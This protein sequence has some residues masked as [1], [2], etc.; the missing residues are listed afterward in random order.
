MATVDGSSGSRATV[1]QVHLE[2]ERVR[3]SRMERLQE[4]T[5]RLAAALTVQEVSDAVLAVTTD[6]LAS[7]SGVVYLDDGTGTLR[8]CAWRGVPP[9][10]EGWQ[11]LPHDSRW[12]LTAAVSTRSPVFVRDRD[13]LLHRYPDLAAIDMPASQ[14]RAIA[15]LPLLHLGRVVGALGVSFAGERTFDEDERRWL[16][17]IASQAA[18]AADRAL[19][20]Q[21]ERQARREAQA[22][23]REAERARD[24][25]ETLY[26][27]AE[28]LSAS[29]L[30]LEA[31]VQRVTDEATRLTGAEFGAFFYNVIDAGGEAYLLY[32]LSGAPKEAFA[33]LGLPRNTPIFAATFG[34][35]AVVRLDDVKK[36][37]RYGTMAPHHGMPKGHLPVTSYLAVP[38]TSR[39]GEVLGGLFFGHSQP[40]R[41]TE[42]HERVTRSLA[43]TA[44]LA[45]DNAKLYRATRDAQDRQ[46]RLVERQGETIRLTELFIGVLAHDL[47]TPLT[48]M[49]TASE[50]MRSRLPSDE[51]RNLKTVERIVSS[52]ERMSRMIEQLLDYTRLRVGHG[53]VLEP[54][55][56][57]LGALVAQAVD[58]LLQGHPGA[59]ITVE[60]Q[61]EL[62]GQWDG[63]RL[64][65]VFSNLIGNAIQHGAGGTIKILVDGR[66][67]ERVE[68]RVHNE[69]AIPAPLLARVFEPMIGGSR[70]KE[71]VGLGLGLFITREIIATHGGSVSVTS[72]E[73]EGTTFA[74]TLPR[75]T[76]RPDLDAV[77]RAGATAA[78][79]STPGGVPEDLRQ[80]EAR[81][82]LLVE[83]VK[84]YAIIM[85]D[86]NGQVQ[87]WNVGAKR[88]KGYDP[89]EIIGQHFSRF[90]EESEGRAAGCQMK[91]EMAARDGRFEDEGWRVRKDG[92]RFWANVVITALRGS[93]GELVGFV[94]VTRDLT[95][96]RALEDERVGRAR[97]EEA[98][99]LRDEFLALASHELKTPLTVMQM[100]LDS[101]RE[102]LGDADEKVSLK[103]LRAAR[104]T[105][106]LAKL[107][108]SLLDV[109]HLTTG[110]LK[111]ARENVDLD[112]IV[113]R[114]LEDLESTAT[115]AG[116]DLRLEVPS[117]L[118]GF[119]DSLRLEQVVN[120]LLS[121]AIKYGAGRPITI[122]A[123]RDGTDAVL[124]IRDHGP[125]IPA[126]DVNRLFR[127]FERAVSLR[128]YGGLGLGLY[129]VQ[130]IVEAHGGQVSAENAEGGG[131]RFA[132]R[133]PTAAVPAG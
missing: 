65:Q 112:A 120:N 96:R 92:S 118:S 30:E 78:L 79:P 15:A 16:S 27:L 108:E 2:R 70:G 53:V 100:Q 77:A 83:S 33:K 1:E 94:K 32:T 12:P 44:A 133:L 49:L 40:A 5:A 13:E 21:G 9:S 101:L 126:A 116:C 35:E 54:K 87:T 69:G 42:Q 62:D 28:S 41:F 76:D 66:Q 90:Y 68:V 58:E 11:V 129:L 64:G 20:Y 89:G 75:A 10:V 71:R 132:L 55:A 109:S 86:P 39:S 50:L 60:Q 95:E 45:I 31:I 127:R 81:F 14:L 107:V 6:V 3:S 25:A 80:S 121:N 46:R 105:E 84:D 17:S 88:I 114:V 103:L 111:L 128:N 119:W 56:A 72:S 18:V 74:V 36:D 34:G 47:R 61:G 104:S 29:Q 73:G 125:G 106:R 98:L 22:A 123:H 102:R 26:R 130:E 99:H 19:L 67:P 8:L 37:P 48:A 115:R 24:E 97:A 110:K 122:A 38:V 4:A 93:T 63:D 7:A 82:R 57:H 43:A 59:T 117:G 131:A 113:A 52:G 85:L 91:L 23:Q 51:P 124:E